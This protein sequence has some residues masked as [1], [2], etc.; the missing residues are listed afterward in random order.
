MEVI[1]DIG[2]ST[3]RDAIV[4]R[5]SASRCWGNV[6]N[7]K[8]PANPENLPTMTG[9][10]EQ[11]LSLKE[12]KT[13]KGRPSQ[14]ETWQGREESRPLAQ[15]GGDDQPQPRSRDKQSLFPEPTGLDS[16]VGCAE[17]VLNPPG[18]SGPHLR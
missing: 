1:Y 3:E 4:S 7:P 8:S 15:P 18:L 6:I 2:G 13:R 11:V 17:F 16:P 10:E 12:P 9:G 14:A 5:F